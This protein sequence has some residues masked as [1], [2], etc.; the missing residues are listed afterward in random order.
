M[1]VTRKLFTVPWYSLNL[2]PLQP[3]SPPVIQFVAIILSEKNV[4]IPLWSHIC[5]RCSVI[6]VH[7]FDFVQLPSLPSRA[8]IT[9]AISTRSSACNLPYPLPLPSKPRSSRSRL[10]SI[11]SKVFLVFLSPISDN[12][13][14]RNCL[15]L[16]YLPVPPSKIIILPGNS[17]K[18]LSC[19][20]AKL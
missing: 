9:L 13:C 17:G 10:L 1:L 11:S 3:R 7:A 16:C 5:A 2:S 19:P 4:K 18:V 8:V 6:C 14:V 15:R 20:S 12:L